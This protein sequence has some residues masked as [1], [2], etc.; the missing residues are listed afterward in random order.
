M[1]TRIR[2]FIT[3]CIL[4]FVGILNAKAT[5][6]SEEKNSGLIGAKES[7]TVLNEQIG[8][9]E[10]ET[11]ESIDYQKEAQ[12][13]NRWII[14][15]IEAKTTKKMIERSSVT[16]NETIH[17]FENEAEAESNDVITDLVQEAQLM[18]KL[19]ADKEEAKA[20]QNMIER[21]FVDP[22]RTNDSFENEVGFESTDF[23]KEAQ[24][25]IKILADKEEAKVFQRLIAENK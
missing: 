22:N 7:L 21:G 12:M 5:T 11:N 10:N 24:L 6:N 17:P 25:M 2:I 15:M 19:I 23:D 13:V 4:A 16:L 8:L 3:V 1:K 9:F 18:T 20:I 14:D